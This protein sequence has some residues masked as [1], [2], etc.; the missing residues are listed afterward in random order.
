MGV[1]EDVSGLLAQVV[2]VERR[3]AQDMFSQPTFTPPEELRA[4]VAGRTQR[5]IASTGEEAVSVVQVYLT[6]E[7]SAPIQP[8][9]RVTLPAPF[10]P[11]QP[12]LLSVD[13][14]PDPLTGQRV[15]VL[16]G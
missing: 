7:G 8:V 15:T 9:D 13:R 6:N 3:I 5:V 14:T 2:T 11:S 1:L 12:R 4:F 10:T 16:Y